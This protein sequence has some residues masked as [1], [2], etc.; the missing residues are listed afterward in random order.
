[1]S[2]LLNHSPSEWFSTYNK[3]RRPHTR[4]RFCFWQDLAGASSTFQQKT[5]C[6]HNKLSFYAAAFLLYDKYK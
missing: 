1:T 6:L 5:Y 3:K 4:L 2:L